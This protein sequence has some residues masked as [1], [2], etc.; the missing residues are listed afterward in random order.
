LRYRGTGNKAS[1]G[2]LVSTAGN[3]KLEVLT[4]HYTLLF[5][6]RLKIWFRLAHEIGRSALRASVKL[7]TSL[8]ELIPLCICSAGSRANR[9]SGDRI[10]GGGEIFR[11]CPDRPWGPSSLQ[12]NVYRVSFPG[13]KRPGRGVDHLPPTRAE[14]KETVDLHLYSLFGHSWPVPG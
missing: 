12:Y 4:R 14:V 6:W 10:P 1:R 13:V 11:T 5:Y 3:F 9:W 8:N 2:R 7:G